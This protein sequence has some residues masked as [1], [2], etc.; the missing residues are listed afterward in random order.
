MEAILK[1][2]SKILE[3]KTQSIY[4]KYKLYSVLRVISALLLVLPWLNVI[5]DFDIKNKASWLVF[6]QNSLPIFSV[7]NAQIVLVIWLV[8]KYIVSELAS[9]F[10]SRF[11]QSEDKFLVAL[12][13]TVDEI[14][15]LGGTIYF[16]LFALNYVSGYI[17]GTVNNQ[18]SN[19]TVIAV[20][21][22]SFRLLIGLY[23]EKKEYLYKRT[24]GYTNFFDSDAKRIPHDAF[25]IYRGKV[26]QIYRVSSD[27]GDSKEW[28]LSEEI[29]LEEAAGDPDGRLRICP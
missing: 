13:M 7:K 11:D 1:Y 19:V 18:P 20:I 15:C 9:R 17:N 8:Y 6:W 29:S 23:R 12:K 25:V 3:G 14:V 28:I 24:R 5:F 21:Y 10:F 27:K 16:F 2:F 4:Y 22:L 26:Y